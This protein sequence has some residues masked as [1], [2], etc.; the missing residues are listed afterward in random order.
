[1]K[2]V[3][4]FLSTVFLIAPAFAQQQASDA[5]TACGN[6]NIN[7]DV[8]VGDAQPAATQSKPGKAQVYFIQDDGPWGERQHFTLRVGIDGAWVGAYKQN[9]YFSIFV[10]PGEHHVCANVQTTYAVASATALAHFTA[11]PGKVYYFRTKYLY[12]IISTSSSGPPYL[13]LDQSDSDEAKY[14]IGMY[15]QAAWVL[16]R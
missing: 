4:L 15:P 1:M 9:S 7:F 3:G 5:T 10:D 11:E 13:D 8:S 14:L 12:G 16:H 6:T 2:V